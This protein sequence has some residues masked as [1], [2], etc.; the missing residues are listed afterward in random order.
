MANNLRTSSPVAH[1]RTNGDL[2]VHPQRAT[3]Y[4]DHFPRVESPTASRDASRAASQCRRQPPETELEAILTDSRHLVDRFWAHDE[5]LGRERPRMKPANSLRPSND[6]SPP[7]G[8]PKSSVKRVRETE[9][10][11]DYTQHHPV[12][13]A[14]STVPERDRR[15]WWND[16]AWRSGDM[17]LQSWILEQ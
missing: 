15:G 12:H 11:G 6:R 13:V 5:P 17:A 3:G 4:R 16:R 2:Y 7:A 9:K 14:L 10:Q 8:L 1:G